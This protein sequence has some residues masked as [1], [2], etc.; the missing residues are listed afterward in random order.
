VKKY[1]FSNNLYHEN[2]ELAVLWLAENM[3]LG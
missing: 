2:N 1:K 3:M